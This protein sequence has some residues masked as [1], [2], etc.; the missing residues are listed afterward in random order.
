M[1]MQTGIR[2]IKRAAQT[3]GSDPS[4]NPVA[5]SDSERERETVD[6]VKAWIADWHER[7]R[8]LQNAADS[9]I[10]SVGARGEGP[11]KR[12]AVLN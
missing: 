4:A 11:T 5:K 6:T 9:I 10:R 7:K 3:G 2:I 1:T 12:V 8:T